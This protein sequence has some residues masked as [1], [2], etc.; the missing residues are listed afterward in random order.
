LG[1]TVLLVS[2]FWAYWPTLAE[3]VGQWRDQPDYSHG[4]LVAPLALFF[5]WSK[6]ATFPLS[7]VRPSLYGLG[8]LLIACAL[9]YVAAALFLGPLD[10][11]T[12]PVWIAGAVWLL[13]GWRVLLW[14][15]PSIVFLWFMVP[16]PFTAES[17]L[18]VPLQAVATKLST[19]CLL[20]LGQPA[21]AEGNTIWL[22]DHQMFVEEACSGLRIF[23]GIFALAFAFAL[24][25]SWSW[26][27]KALA[28]AAALPIAIVANVA[29]VVTTGLLYQ[30]AS[31]K[32]ARHFSH[33]L[34]GLVMIPFAALLFWL[35]LVYLER[36]FPKAEV[37]S[38][39]EVGFAE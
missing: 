16:I 21:I 4:F 10:G 2:F 12:I 1:G 17:W 15:L 7:E 13:T 24:F 35:F 28:L 31:S 5:L 3:I 38:A 36:L 20:M 14:S 11:W 26:W 22:G 6:R 9:R 37:I 18:S 19:A 34:A 29:R 39:Y 25:S 8:L 33:D 30:L 27:Q 23:V 32:A